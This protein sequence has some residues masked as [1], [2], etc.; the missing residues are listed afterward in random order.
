MEVGKFVITMTTKKES[1]KEK[2][3]AIKH[4]KAK[5]VQKGVNMG[6]PHL[7][8]EQGQGLCVGLVEALA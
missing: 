8:I 1:K 4:G 7:L 5:G 3:M 2:S 6:F